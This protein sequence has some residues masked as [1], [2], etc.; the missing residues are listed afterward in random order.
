MHGF[1]VLLDGGE[2]ISDPFKPGLASTAVVS[3]H[4]WNSKTYKTKFSEN[5]VNLSMHEFNSDILSLLFLRLQLIYI[6]NVQCTQNNL[7]TRARFG[8]QHGKKINYP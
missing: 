8:H 4:M 2:N 3:L 1:R 5:I 6:K 7:V